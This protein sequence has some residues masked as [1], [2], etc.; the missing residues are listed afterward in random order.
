MLDQPNVKL[1]ECGCGEHTPLATQTK[2]R[3]GHFKGRP[4]RFVQGHNSRSF[5]GERTP[6]NPSGL[7]QCGCGQ[8][9]P[10]APASHTKLGWVKG[11]P[12]RFIKGHVARTMNGERHYAWRGPDASYKT[13]HTWLNRRFPKAGV[14]EQCGAEAATDYCFL[15][16]PRPHTRDRGDYAELCRFCHRRLDSKKLVT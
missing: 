6:P 12:I 8:I 16:H 10:L 13:L 3:K 1:C 15:H 2:R 14:C 4:L 7:C 9:T 5:R 11:E